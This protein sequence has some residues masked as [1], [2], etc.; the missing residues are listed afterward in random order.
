M[1]GIV[2]DIS[3][4]WGQVSSPRKAS[5]PAA[6]SHVWYIMKSPKGFTDQ[7]RVDATCDRL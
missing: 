1:E 5:F 7:V 6:N 4:K 2:T 3:L